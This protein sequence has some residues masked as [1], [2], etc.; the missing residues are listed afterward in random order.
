MISQNELSSI[1]VLTSPNDETIEISVNS[2][3]M[4][5]IIESAIGFFDGTLVV[6]RI[7]RRILSVRSGSDLSKL[8]SAKY[9]DVQKVVNASINQIRERR[10][11][12]TKKAKKEIRVLGEDQWV[13]SEID[14]MTK[15]YTKALEELGKRKALGI[16][17]HS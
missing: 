12:I 3:A 9:K 15:K 4:I 8:K 16:Q 14:S 6:S 5:P 11:N 7:S 13:V 1:A 17:N 10:V 2:E